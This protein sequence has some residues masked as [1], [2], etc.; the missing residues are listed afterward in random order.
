MSQLLVRDLEK[1]LVAKLKR[2]A[3][4]QGISAEELH[5]RILREALSRPARDK[6]SLIE[7]LI[8]PEGEVAPGVELDLT[9]GRELEAR[10]LDLG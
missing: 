8:S 3:A 7:F 9:R 4:A 5:R 6:P 2:R 1:T 10:D